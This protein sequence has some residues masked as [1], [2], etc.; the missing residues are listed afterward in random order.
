MQVHSELHVTS[1]LKRVL[2]LAVS[3]LELATARIVVIRLAVIFLTP[4]T[5]SKNL[6]SRKVP[7][8]S[9]CRHSS[10]ALS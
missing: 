1:P 4:I 6:K 2:T 5:R 9:N 10:S 8:R 7:I 3:K